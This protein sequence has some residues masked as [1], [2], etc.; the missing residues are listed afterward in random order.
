MSPLLLLPP[1]LLACLWSY[2]DLPSAL[3]LAASSPLLR[4]LLGPLDWRALLTRVPCWNQEV[5]DAVVAFLRGGK[6]WRRKTDDR[7]GW[8]REELLDTIIRRFPAVE[9]V[10]KMKDITWTSGD[11]ML[12]RRLTTSPTSTT[13][14][15]DVAISPKGLE[16]LALAGGA[17]LFQLVEVRLQLGLSPSMLTTLHSWATT[18]HALLTTLSIFH[19]SCTTE[20]QVVKCAELLGRCRRWRVEELEV[21]G[22]GEE[23]WRGLARALGVGMPREGLQRVGVLVTEVEQMVAGVREDLRRL[24]RGTSL[25]WVVDGEVVDMEE[26]DERRGWGELVGRMEAKVKFEEL[27]GENRW[28]ELEELLEEEQAMQEEEEDEEEEHEK[29]A[30]E[31]EELINV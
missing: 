16:L 1:E 21:W 28:E 26:E 3:A 30:L 7:R 18:Q 12:V 23:G 15:R 24:W 31:M 11:S 9:E 20:E 5:V 14:N 29:D 2:L 27:I 17:P 25:Y 19:V 4:P 6:E 10:W 8:R 13:S 22:A